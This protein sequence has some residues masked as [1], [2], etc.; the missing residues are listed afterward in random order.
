MI[1]DVARGLPHRPHLVARA[2]N[3]EWLFEKTSPANSVQ[4]IARCVAE[5]A[6]AVA[7][8]P[9][10]WPTS[11]DEAGIA[12]QTWLQLPKATLW[13]ETAW[14]GI[15]QCRPPIHNFAEH[16]L[17]VG[18]LRWALH[19]ILPYPTFLL[20]DAHLAARL[21]VTVGSLGSEAMSAE[22]QALFG[23]YEYQGQLKSIQGRR[24]WRAGVEHAIF[25]LTENTPGSI[26]VLRAQLQERVPKLVFQE[27]GRLFPVLDGNFQTKAVLAHE[28]DGIAEVRPDDWPTFADEAW[29]LESDIENEPM[30][31]AT[32]VAVG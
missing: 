26:S 5:L 1:G 20:D 23:A 25:N 27:K 10:K 12:L 14:E 7:G 21:R 29:A 13:S 3:L 4:A 32:R 31:K 28:A 15:I 6:S 22:F 19:K 8:L 17:G 11:A 9:P 18:V 30:L 24:W 16:T 2:H